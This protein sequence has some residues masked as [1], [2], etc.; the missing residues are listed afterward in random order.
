M[1]DEN[2]AFF[3]TIAGGI[4]LGFG[5]IAL[6]R[7]ADLLPRIHEFSLNIFFSRK[8][9][10]GRQG[11]HVAKYIFNYRLPTEIEIEPSIHFESEKV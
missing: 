6:R 2:S 10:S 8:P 1:P 7:A 11:R 3:F 9:A 5:R 4:F